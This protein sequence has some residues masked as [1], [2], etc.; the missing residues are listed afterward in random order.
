MAAE[1]F[2]DAA[3]NQFNGF[4]GIGEPDSAV[5]GL[6][7]RGGNATVGRMNNG[8]ARV[9][10]QLGPGDGFGHPGP[11]PAEPALSPGPLPELD[12]VRLGDPG[13]DLAGAFGDQ[14]HAVA[15]HPLLRGL[16]LE[17]PPKGT[18]LPPGWLDRWFAATRSILELLYAQD[19]HRG[20]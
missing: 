10:G 5:P 2:P 14:G 17:L 20:A 3:G 12:P 18:Q 16:L 8:R 7:L 6:P 11:D 19:P 15:D 9:P 1:S 4:R 13:L